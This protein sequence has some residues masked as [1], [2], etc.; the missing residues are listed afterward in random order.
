MPWA[1]TAQMGSILLFLQLQYEHNRRPTTV[2]TKH[3]PLF[4]SAEVH[5]PPNYQKPKN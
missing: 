3:K 4:S 5:R 1:A 2:M